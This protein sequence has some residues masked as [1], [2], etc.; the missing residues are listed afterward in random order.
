MRIA[1]VVVLVAGLLVASGCTWMS[2]TQ[3]AWVADN[4]NRVDAYAALS[5]SGQTTP[6]QD[7]QFIAQDKA[8]WDLWAQKIQNGLAAPSLLTGGN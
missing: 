7:K 3:K 1:Y 6:A 5:A 8:S 2:G 4:A